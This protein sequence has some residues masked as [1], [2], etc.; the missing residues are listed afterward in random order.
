MRIYSKR[1]LH[2]IVWNRILPIFELSSGLYH[3]F[4][5]TGSHEYSEN[6]VKSLF[7]NQKIINV[8]LITHFLI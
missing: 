7:N 4:A 6:L 2:C 1:E 5:K 3:E 8:I